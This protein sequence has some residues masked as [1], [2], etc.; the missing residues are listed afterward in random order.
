M[1]E[2]TA[3]AGAIENRHLE[4]VPE[5]ERHGKVWR[6]GP[7]WFLGNFQPFTVALAFLGPLLGL[8]G[9]WTSIAGVGGILFGTL[10]MAAHAAQG[11]Q[12]GLPQMIQ[13][14]AQ[15]GY[16]GV[17]LPVIATTFTFVAFNVVDV[18]IIKQGLL[19][20]FGWNATSVAIVIS[21][22]AALLAIYGHD[23]IH[24]VFITIFWLS[25]P[26]WVIV[27][28]GIFRGHAGGH[29]P[30]TGG[31]NAA[32]FF[33]MFA[34]AASYNITYAPYVSDYSRYLAKNSSRAGIITAVFV[35]A[36]G[37]PMWLIP[38]GAWM[39]T[40]L[41]VSDSLSGIYSAGNHSLA[42][43]G[44]ILTLVAVLALVATM[45]INA[46][47]GMLSVVTILDSLRPVASGSRV[48]VLT[49]IGLTIVW[50]VLSIA[51]SNSTT[52]LNNSLIVMLYLLAPWTSVNLIDFY[53]V[54]HGRFAITEFFNPAGI[55]GRWG[56]KGIT[57]YLVG[58]LV[59][60]P[61]MYIPGVYESP[62]AKALQGVDVSW[63]LGLFV[64]GGLYFLL[65]RG[66]NRDAE[67]VAIERSE[68]ELANPS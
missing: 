53:A 41:G 19:H 8:N 15:F 16:R 30:L 67:R 64:G 3:A 18:V 50:F 47:S 24:R 57:S 12:L 32:A 22:A 55:Y 26:F 63:V 25:L 54:R 59:E 27:T 62:G 13:S 43:V 6:Q 35:G 10:F 20:I 60:I 28:V 7:F 5:S 38:V 1:T 40:R 37:S 11:P 42:H 52:A 36:A 14:R 31:F 29:G 46:Y 44:T 34:V 68:R 61:F 45:G 23:W 17:I 49:I 21:V 56:S 51:L 58:I 65:T 9:L 2:L 48:R 4:Y 66:L 33:A 39:A